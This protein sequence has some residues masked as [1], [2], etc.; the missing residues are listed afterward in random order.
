MSHRFATGIDTCKFN[1]KIFDHFLTYELNV[2]VVLAK[3]ILFESLD[4]MRTGSD[5]EQTIFTIH[6]CTISHII[7]EMPDAKHI[8]TSISV[9]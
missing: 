1:R 2:S 7:N 5:R 8:V 3:E 6:I 4:R 9:Y